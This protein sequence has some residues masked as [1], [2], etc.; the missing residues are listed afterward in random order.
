MPSKDNS[1]DA[2][3]TLRD[4]LQAIRSKKGIIGYILKAADSASVDLND[5]SKI[6]D[7]AVVSATTLE[8]GEKLAKVFGIGDLNKV[9]LEGER[10]KLLL[11]ARG[12]HRISI[13]MDKTVDHEAVGK[14][15][16]LA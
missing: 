13:F 5:P 12:D 9:V 3:T 2:I 8:E 4:S 14:D 16:N 10:M 1:D 11:L 7:Y 15:L 6:V